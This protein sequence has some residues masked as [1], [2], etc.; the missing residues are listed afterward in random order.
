MKRERERERVKERNDRTKWIRQFA[1]STAKENDDVNQISQIKNLV[2]N[3]ARESQF[4]LKRTKQMIY[5]FQV[6]CVSTSSR[7]LVLDVRI[8]ALIS[9]ICIQTRLAAAFWPVWKISILI[10]TEIIDQ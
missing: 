8:N 1:N 4:E 7:R 3:V 9:E 2:E 6:K 5:F 10:S